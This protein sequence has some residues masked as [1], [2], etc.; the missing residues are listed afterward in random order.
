M[1]DTERGLN[2]REFLSALF[3]AV[4]GALSWSPSFG[5]PGGR[6]GSLLKI[7]LEAHPDEVSLF[8]GALTRVLR[9]YGEVLEGDPRRLRHLEGSYL[10]PLLYLRTGE[11]LEVLFKNE[12]MDPTTVH[13][14][15]V[16]VPERMD[17][18]PRFSVEPF[19]EYRYAF[20]VINRAGTYWYHPHAHML[21]GEQAYFGLAGGILI[22]DDVE[23][24]LP[25]PRGEQDVLL[26]VQD[27][28]F[29]DN[30]QLLYFRM[31]GHHGML[32]DKILINGYPD[33]VL[34]VATR[35]YRLRVLNGSNARI[36]KLAWEDGLPFTVIGTD[37]GLL[38]R[39]VVKPYVM[40]APGERVELWEDFRPFSVG[41]VRNLVSAEW[42]GSAVNFGDPPGV[43]PQGAP[44]EVMSFYVERK[45]WDNLILPGF[46]RPLEGYRW[47][48]ARNLKS[49]RLFE[50][51]WEG[52]W[53]INGRVFE[54]RDVALEERVPWN[55]IEVVQFR[56]DVGDRLMAH[57]LHFHGPMFQVG[58]RQVDPRYRDGWESVRE[59]YVDSGWKD[60]LLLMPGESV[61]LLFKWGPYPGLYLYHCHNLEHE[62]MGM[63]RNYL[64]G[65]TLTS[66]I[67][68]G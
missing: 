57:P 5:G 8:P 62:D 51:R 65:P 31:L 13:W 60:T 32:G 30:N 26:V 22:E 3:A 27:R 34:P 18:H 35:V 37:G 10:G 49:P 67:G 7:R 4:G 24:S 38:E 52:E 61:R 44:M 40:L 39:P 56:N 53:T 19:E 2:R 42:R 43:P 20:E 46:L 45:D 6:R 28:K 9:Y 11:R 1:S 50:F 41:T 54:M 33:F 29:D 47:Q 21:S 12:L 15:G 64:I 63:M 36:Y 17:G 48:D 16:N 25:L 59:G 68:I 66:G 14:H 23:A 58:E 55:Q